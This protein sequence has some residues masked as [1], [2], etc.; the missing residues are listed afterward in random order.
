ML[1]KVY[2][3]PS[4]S[5]WGAPMLFVKKKDS[6]LRLLIDYRELNK[7]MIKDSVLRPY[8]DKFVIVSRDDI[9]IYSKN[10]EEHVEPLASMFKLL[11]EHQL[12]AKLSKSNLFQTKVH[13][14]GHVV[15]KEGIV[16]DPEKIR[17]IMERE[18]PKNVDEVRSFMGLAGYYTRLIGNFSRIAYPVTSLKR[19]G[20]KF[21]WIEECVA[22]F[23][24]LNYL[25]TNALVLKIA[26]PDKV[27]VVCTYAC[28]RGLGGFL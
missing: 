20:K 4:V 25:L 8:L 21:K 16:V 5:P 19:K 10:E 9:L 1:D 7:A 11:R 13:Y 17:A 27:F 23:E 18:T 26:D 6:T 12:Y 28:K 2:I 22:S 3:R 14:L 24:Q 15:S